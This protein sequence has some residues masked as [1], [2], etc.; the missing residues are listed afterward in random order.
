MAILKTGTS[1]ALMAKRAP[2][3]AKI[4]KAWALRRSALRL[5]A[6]KRKQAKKSR[7]GRV[8][9]LKDLTLSFA[10][11]LMLLMQAMRPIELNLRGCRKVF[12]RLP[13]KIKKILPWPAKCSRLATRRGLMMLKSP[14]G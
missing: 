4:S 2:L 13:A 12:F 7:Q 14:V 1:P 6:P 8:S 3:L 5:K 10:P 11:C 9:I